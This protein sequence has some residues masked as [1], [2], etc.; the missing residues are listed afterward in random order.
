M[1]HRHTFFIDAGKQP[2]PEAFDLVPE[3]KGHPAELRISHLPA[4]RE[5]KVTIDSDDLDQAV[6][7]PWTT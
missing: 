6:S 4:A 3:K 2:K 1:K 7:H 5:W